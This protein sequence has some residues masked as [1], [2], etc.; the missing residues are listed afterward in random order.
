MNSY[1]LSAARTPEQKAKMK[2]LQQLNICAFCPEHF[3]EFHD[4]PIEFETPYWV[5][6]KNDYP[7]KGTS[8]HLL[9][10][11]KIHVKHIKELSDT[12]RSDLMQVVAQIETRFN[13]TS[14]SLG[15]RVGDFN[16]NGGSV[17]HLHA[18]IIVSDF[19]KPEEHLPVFM[20]LTS[21]PHGA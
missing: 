11:P 16:Y 20:K 17:T 13:L 19:K 7:Y 15:M 4:N 9:I 21:V 5:V 8:L 1:N 12:A 18:H 14:F 6:S 3:V 2:K 10:I